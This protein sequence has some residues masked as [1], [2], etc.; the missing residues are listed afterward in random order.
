MILSPESDLFVELDDRA[1]SFKTRRQGL[2]CL[3]LCGLDA[4]VAF[5][6][7]VDPQLSPS[8]T[9]FVQPDTVRRPKVLAHSSQYHPITFIPY[10]SEHSTAR[11]SL[12]AILEPLLHFYLALDF[13]YS[14]VSSAPQPMTKCGAEFLPVIGAQT[15]GGAMQH[16]GFVEL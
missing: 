12:A 11:V 4:Q 6:V 7:T 2:H 1:S 16:H 14:S 13:S 10:S 3:L 9:I 8:V 15:I 5:L